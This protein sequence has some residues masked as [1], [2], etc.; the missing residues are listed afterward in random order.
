MTAAGAPQTQQTQPQQGIGFRLGNRR[1]GGELHPITFAT[2]G[3][4]DVI[5]NAVRS[6]VTIAKQ[7]E[8]TTV[9][10]ICAPGVAGG[11]LAYQ[12]LA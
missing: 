8:V 12:L 11:G 2:V 3:A 9:V 10:V 5:E 1:H 6:S 4:Q 7:V